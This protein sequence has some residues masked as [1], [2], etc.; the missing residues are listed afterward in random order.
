MQET[1][2]LLLSSLEEYCQH[3]KAWGLVWPLLGFDR[4]V[5]FFPTFTDTYS[6]FSLM[7]RR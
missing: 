5:Q 3:L 4:L 6:P 2:C 1:D 7:Y